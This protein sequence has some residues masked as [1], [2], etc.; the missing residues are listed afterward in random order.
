MRFA[1]I[2]TNG[3]PCLKQAY[4]AIRPQVDGVVIVDT[5]GDLQVKHPWTVE[6]YRMIQA[7]G[8]ANISRWWNQGLL[9]AERIHDIRTRPRTPHGQLMWDPVE[10]EVAIIND[11][12]IVPEGWVNAVSTEM[13]A[14]G[15]V[16]G[17]SGGHDVT[18]REA[19]AV[20]L[21]MRMQGFAF[22]L[23]GE[24][25]LRANENLHWY[26][27]DDYIDWESRVAGGMSMIRGYPV[28][29]LHPNEQLT[30]EIH[31]QIARDA[32]TFFDLYG[33]RPW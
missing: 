13:R 14:R 3:R 6:T 20:P 4:D 16:A 30:P 9:W 17:C 23:A 25:G 27:T 32:Q 33:R 31:E 11:D 18:L 28:E 22:I 21:D 8:G 26:F 1:V 24:R 7:Q 15:A 19:V 2:P 12:A 10:Y 5:V 29:H